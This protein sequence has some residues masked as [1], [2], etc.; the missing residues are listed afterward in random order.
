MSSPRC[1]YVSLVLDEAGGGRVVEAHRL[2]AG[3]RV[4]R[5]RPTSSAVV[6]V[7]LEQPVGL[8]HRAAGQL[9]ATGDPLADDLPWWATTLRSRRG[10]RM[11]ALHS[12]VDAWPMSRRRRRNAK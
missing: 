7:V 5:I 9:L 1:S 10:I 4:E 2:D 6:D 11:Q 12:Q 8:D 3:V